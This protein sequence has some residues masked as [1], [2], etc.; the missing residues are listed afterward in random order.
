MPMRA[1]A[2][3]FAFTTM[4]ACMSSDP[5]PGSQP[6][7]GPNTLQKHIARQQP[8]PQLQQQHAPPPPQYGAAPPSYHEGG[9]G[10]DDVHVGAQQQGD[11]FLPSAALAFV[12]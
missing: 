5:A 11:V 1:M 7:R 2:S 12:S 10:A 8:P 6:A 3:H 4:G 9:I